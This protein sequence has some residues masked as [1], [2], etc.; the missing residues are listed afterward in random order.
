[1]QFFNNYVKLFVDIKFFMSIY[2]AKKP[3]CSVSRREKSTSCESI[4]FTEKNA[5]KMQYF[6]AF[7]RVSAY[8]VTYMVNDL[9]NSLTKRFRFLRQGCSADGATNRCID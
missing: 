6:V 9:H 5:I 8:N 7:P 4:D 1:M 2:Y 3:I